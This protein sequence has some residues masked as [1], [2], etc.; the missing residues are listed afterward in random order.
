[1][2]ADGDQ[3]SQW[4]AY[5]RPADGYA[6][7]FDSLALRKAVESHWFLL[8][9]EYEEG[10]QIQVVEKLLD[11]VEADF[12]RNRPTATLD[13]C[14]AG[15]S[16]YFLIAFHMVAPILKHRA[17]RDEQEWRLVTKP[18][19]HS[20]T[21]HRPASTMLVPFVACTYAPDGPSSP[22]SEIVVGPSPHSDLEHRAVAS[23]RK[24]LGLK[25]AVRSSRIPY[26]PW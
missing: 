11:E 14:T 5:C 13:T 16:G 2:S 1:M 8:P 7:G 25:V 6:I 22:I 23:M 24:Q 17:F 10:A 18:F 3:L 4:R 26:R 20:V 19:A 9:C 21:G 12:Y 15:A